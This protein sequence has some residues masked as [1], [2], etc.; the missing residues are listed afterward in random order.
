[1]AA[2]DPRRREPLSDEIADLLRDLAPQVLGALTRRYGDFGRAEDAV[3][4]A[5]IA[6][7]RT[8][9]RDGVPEQP[10]GW[11]A[12]V[13]A[14]RYLDQVRA[15]SARRR[16]E[17]AV[18]RASPEAGEPAGDDTLELLFLCCH[19]A[20]APSAQVALTL[21][22]VGGLTTAEIAAFSPSCC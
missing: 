14:R 16:R 1:V 12:T 8:W 22:A 11:L 20:L 4:E 6:A 17:L 10:R 7:L 21:R 5:M 2:H 18:H 15:D 3:Q 9:T 13:A 19:P